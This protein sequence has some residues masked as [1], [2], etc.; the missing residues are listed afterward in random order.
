MSTTA[1]A[2]IVYG[3]LDGQTADD[4]TAETF[5]VA[6]GQ[7]GRFNPERG[8]LRP[9]LLRLATNMVARHRRTEARHYRALARMG[10]FILAVSSAFSLARGFDSGWNTEPSTD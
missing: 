6:F 2:V 3:R 8:G 5:L 4:I 1:T 7:L 10:R 9:W